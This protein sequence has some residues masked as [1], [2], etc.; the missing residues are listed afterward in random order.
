MF[1]GYTGTNCDS[2]TGPDSSADHRANGSADPGA[3]A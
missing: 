1:H 3:N 2:Y